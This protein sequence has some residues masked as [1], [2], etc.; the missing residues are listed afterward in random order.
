MGRD[1]PTDL[2]EPSDFERFSARLERG[3]ESLSERLTRAGTA[4]APRTVGAEV[5][6]FV[7]DTC[8]AREHFT[9]SPVSRDVAPAEKIRDDP[10][11]HNRSRGAERRSGNDAAVIPR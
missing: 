2:F 10:D 5:E 11:F 3:L 8:L 6:L 7:D 1:I 4:E 9:H